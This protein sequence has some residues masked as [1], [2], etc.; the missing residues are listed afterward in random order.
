MFKL[1]KWAF[2]L[3]Q[4]TERRRIA[5]I[6]A[7]SRMY[8]PYREGLGDKQRERKIREQVIAGAVNDIIDNITQ[9]KQTEQRQFSVL[10]PKGDE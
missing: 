4:Q 2:Q 5:H 10:F 9:P 3:G 6:L 1:V 8:V 7:E